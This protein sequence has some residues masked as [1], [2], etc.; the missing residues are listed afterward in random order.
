MSIRK[1]QFVLIATMLLNGCTLDRSWFQMNSNSPVPFF[2]L[3]FRLGKIESP[4]SPILPVEEQFA[5]YWDNEISIEPQEA[6]S[7][8]LL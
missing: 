1:L 8:T 3:D 2:G 6:Q 5:V 7:A 4:Y